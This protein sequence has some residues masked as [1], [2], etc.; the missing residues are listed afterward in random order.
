MASDQ[1]ENE[2]YGNV[3]ENQNGNGDDEN[4]N[5]FKAK[6]DKKQMKDIKILFLDV[7][8]VLCA[9]ENTVDNNSD[10]FELEKDQDSGLWISHLKR[11]KNIIEETD[12]YIVLSSA[13]R[14]FENAKKLLFK[15]MKSEKVGIDV[16]TRY[17]GD[18]PSNLAN[19][20]IEIKTWLSEASKYCNVIEFVAVDDI[21]LDM[22]KDEENKNFM[23]GHFVHTDGKN[24]MLDEEKKAII[25]ILNE[26]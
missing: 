5:K 18:T 14:L 15:A 2:G 19:R 20:V 4:A 21:P 23:H 7:D 9:L 12:C 13:W 25:A 3:N 17:L 11:I 24:G 6:I 16:D 8:G 1:K 10:D 22:L 26:N